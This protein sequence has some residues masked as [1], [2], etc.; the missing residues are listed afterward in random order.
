MPKPNKIKQRIKKIYQIK[1]IK[2]RGRVINKK[3]SEPIIIL[4]HSKQKEIFL[5]K[6]ISL[7]FIKKNMAISKISLNFNQLQ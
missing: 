3:E 5:M 7:Q 6:S 4:F 2:V 1:L